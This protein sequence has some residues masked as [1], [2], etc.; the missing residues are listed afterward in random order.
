ML[1]PL[2]S[3]EIKDAA[4]SLGELVPFLSPAMEMGT[5][6][7][8]G[9]GFCAMVWHIGSCPHATAAGDSSP[10]LDVVAVSGTEVSAALRCLGRLPE[11]EV[12]S[13]C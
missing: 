12:V 7:G 1:W 8:D 5:R 11:V 10:W 6:G 3:V 2:L 13:F 4:L 9:D